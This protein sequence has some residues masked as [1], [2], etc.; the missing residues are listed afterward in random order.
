MAIRGERRGEPRVR[1]MAI[2]KL[3][4]ASILTLAFI[5]LNNKRIGHADAH[6]FQVY[7]KSSSFRL[8]CQTETPCYK[9]ERLIVALVFIDVITV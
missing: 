1:R 8:L 4:F 7:G 3:N 9:D 2:M 5:S 6:T